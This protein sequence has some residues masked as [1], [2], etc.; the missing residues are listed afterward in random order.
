MIDLILT[1]MVYTN[2]R[3]RIPFLNATLSFHFEVVSDSLHPHLFFFIISVQVVW[4]LFIRQHSASISFISLF[5]YSYDAGQDVCHLE[6]KAQTKI[7]NIF[8][9]ECNS[10]GNK[11]D[12]VFVERH[13]TKFSYSIHTVN[14]RKPPIKHTPPSILKHSL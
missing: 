7:A 1:P 12:R 8:T 9:H 3:R 2:K 4:L 10:V 6:Y 5:F 14:E 11:E 13:T